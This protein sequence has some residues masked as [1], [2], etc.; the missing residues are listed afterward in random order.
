K[1]YRKNIIKT[2]MIMAFVESIMGILQHFLLWP[3]D[4][5]HL[6][7]A[8]RLGRMAFGA[9]QNC[10]FFAGLLTLLMGL[11]VATYVS[12]K[13]RK[14]Q[15]YAC[16][17]IIAVVYLCG[18]YTATRI[19]WLGAIGVFISLIGFEIV[20]F[21]SNRNIKDN[22]LRLKRIGIV[23]VI[24]VAVTG[25]VYLSKDNC[26][27]S[28]IQEF[29]ADSENL[30]EEGNIDRYGS[31]RGVI[32][33]MGIEALPKYW[34]LGVGVDNYHYT[35]KINPTYDGELYRQPRAH[36]EY[37][38][39]LVDE[40]VFAFALYMSFIFYTFI[41]TVKYLCKNK[42]NSDNVYKYIFLIAFCSY[43][44][45][46]LVNSSI[47]NIAPYFWI[48]VG[49]LNE[50]TEMRNIKTFNSKNRGEQINNDEK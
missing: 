48:T 17:V 18:L 42:M 19:F 10:N 46:A 31:S 27:V 13:L 49:L 20:Y 1:E 29:K 40:G 34:V 4:C 11:C 43:S 12:V 24:V 35:Y 6:T 9:A 28:Q 23:L 47:V 50:R 2:L 25:G 3:V 16:L 22:L 33:R 41:K 39:V 21:I 15:K 26:I 32:W 5:E 37:L 30:K 44:I 8:H 36:C 38:Q 7:K 14:K 45:Q